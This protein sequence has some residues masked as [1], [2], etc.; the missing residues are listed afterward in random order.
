[1]FEASSVCGTHYVLVAVFGTASRIPA[2]VIVSSFKSILDQYCCSCLF[3]DC[4]GSKDLI[5]VECEPVLLRK[6]CACH[7]SGGHSKNIGRLMS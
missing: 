4:L 7:A 3:R 5:R 6:T 1:M 2:S